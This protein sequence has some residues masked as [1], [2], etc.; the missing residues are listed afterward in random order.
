MFVCVWA[1]VCVVLVCACMPVVEGIEDGEEGEV[2]GLFNQSKSDRT[3]RLRTRPSTGTGTGTE[4]SSYSTREGKLCF[5][6]AI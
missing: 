4:V 5:F 3:S 1:C 6:G 2:E